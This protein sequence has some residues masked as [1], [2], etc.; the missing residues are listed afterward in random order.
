MDAASLPLLL[1]LH[2]LCSRMVVLRAAAGSPVLLDD[3]SDADTVY[4]LLGAVVE[5]LC[6]VELGGTECEEARDPAVV[7]LEME[8]RDGERERLLM[9]IKGRNVAEDGAGVL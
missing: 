3:G 6:F 9:K 5:P 8:Q 7:M 2:V 1:Q 4:D